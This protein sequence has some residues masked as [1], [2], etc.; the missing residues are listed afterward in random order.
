MGSR[1]APLVQ[2]S[3]VRTVAADELW[4]SPSYRRE[5][6]AIHVTWVPD[7]AAV[8]AVLPELEERLAAFAPRPHWAK[9]SGID[10][11]ALA[12]RYPRLADFVA[13]AAEYDPA[14]VFRNEWADRYLAAA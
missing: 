13:L 4:L 12:Q 11:D 3:E 9:V 8:G 2:V 5:T 6:V 14:G 10:A 7:A 1:L